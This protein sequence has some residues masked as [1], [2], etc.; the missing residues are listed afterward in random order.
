MIIPVELTASAF[1]GFGEV[2]SALADG[3]S[4]ANGG[5]ARRFDYTSTLYNDRPHARANMVAVRCAPVSLPLQIKLLEKHPHSSQTFVPM[6]CSRYLVCV[7][8]TGKDGLPQLDGLK[9]FICRPGQGINYH[10]GTWHHPL[11]VLDTP[12]QFAMLVW[13]DGTK[14]DCVEWPLPQ[15]LMVSTG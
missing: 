7:A 6:L 15:P 1:A 8:P 14:D 2:V 13:E 11:V 10:A 12:A 9:A 3:G 5:T 4:S